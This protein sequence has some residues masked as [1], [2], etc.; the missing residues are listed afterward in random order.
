M[1]HVPTIF[2]HD[3]DPRLVGRVLVGSGQKDN[4]FLHFHVGGPADRTLGRLCTGS[5]MLGHGPLLVESER[6]KGFG[7]N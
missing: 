7:S 1:K 4:L 6:H 3:V 2:A 5:K